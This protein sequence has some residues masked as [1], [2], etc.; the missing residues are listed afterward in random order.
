M[1]PC[2]SVETQTAIGRQAP[3]DRET[4]LVVEDRRLLS[5]MQPRQAEVVR[6]KPCHPRM[7]GGR[8]SITAEAVW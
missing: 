7:G 5:L 2:F 4:M 8:S 1:F 3:V 6:L